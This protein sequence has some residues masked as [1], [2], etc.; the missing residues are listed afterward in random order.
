MQDTGNQAPRAAGT[1]NAS[2]AGTSRTAGLANEKDFIIPCEEAGVR[3]L[4]PTE[5]ARLQ[6]FPDDWNECGADG[7]QLPDTVRYRQF[8]NA[9]TVNVAEW[10]GK[11][12]LTM[13]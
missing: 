9:V 4:T 1:L 8:G 7:V 5:C 3:R 6:G 12:L 13:S 11:R 2:G 10:I